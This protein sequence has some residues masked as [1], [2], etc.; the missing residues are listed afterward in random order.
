MDETEE[1]RITDAT[2]EIIETRITDAMEEILRKYDGRVAEQLDSWLLKL[3][4]KLGL[5]EGNMSNAPQHYPTA[6][7]ADFDDEDASGVS[8]EASGT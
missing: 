5:V 2:E 7:T 4:E 6:A 1:T 3:D 8:S